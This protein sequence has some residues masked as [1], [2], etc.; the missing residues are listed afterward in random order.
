MNSE[1][2]FAGSLVAHFERI[3]EQ[4]MQGLPI[5]NPGLGVEA[6]GVRDLSEQK[7]CVLITPWF[8]NLVLW[9][10]EGHWDNMEEGELV[11]VDLPHESLEFTVCRDPE[12]GSY[13]SAVLFRTM[14]D[15]PDQDTARE[16]ALE[17]LRRL[18]ADAEQTERKLVKRRALFT[19]LGAS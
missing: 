1:L 12:I 10:G 18:F 14:T 17:S 6:V 19:G 11:S 15:F 16:I 2:D 4:H 9:A 8:M 5:V 3:Y 7:V 13:L